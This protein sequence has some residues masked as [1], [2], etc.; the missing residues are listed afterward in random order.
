MFSG[1]EL[2]HTTSNSFQA[3]TDPLPAARRGLAHAVV[4]TAERKRMGMG[5]IRKLAGCT[6]I[7]RNFGGILKRTYRTRYVMICHVFCSCHGCRLPWMT[8]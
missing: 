5:I 6:E 7:G 1:P 4:S 2:V 8:G 3:T